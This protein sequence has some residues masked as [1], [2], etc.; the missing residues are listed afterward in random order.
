[1]Q[2][3]L[4]SAFLAAYLDPAEPTPSCAQY[5]IGWEGAEA[6]LRAAHERTIQRANA[7]Q[8]LPQSLGIPRAGARLPE[9]RSEAT[10]ELLFLSREEKE[11]RG[12]AAQNPP[13]FSRGSL[14]EGYGYVLRRVGETAHQ[15]CL[16]VT[17][18]EKPADLVL[19]EGTR[20]LVRV[21][22]L[23]G[24]DADA[25]AQLLAE[26]G[27]VGT[28]EERA[29]L[30][31]AYA[32][33]PLALK[34]VAETIADLF[35]GEIGPFLKQSVVIFGSIQELL[36]EQIA[37][38]SAVEQIVLRWLAIVREPLS[39]EDLLVLL[40][41]PGPAG[42]MLSAVDNLRRRSLIER[43]KLPGSFTLHSVVLGY[44]TRLLIEE[45]THEITQGQ[46]SRLIEHGLSHAGAREDVR[47]TQE[48]LIVAPILAHLRSAYPGRAEVEERLLSLLAQ[49]R[50]RADYAQGY[51]PA[52]L[53]ALLRELRGHLRGLDLSQL[54]LRGAY[55]QGVE[56][57]DTTLAGATLRETVWTSALDAT[58][59]VAISGNGQ[60]W[61]SLGRD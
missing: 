61:A 27:V 60:Y 54:A 8:V 13:C 10:Q 21:L 40:V 23:G 1:V 12:S 58:N 22:R 26:K 38:L 30:V 47:Q 4:Y 20:S 44:V 35:V 14:Q 41:A 6:R 18:R 2:R 15:S 5:V 59:A 56:M 57:Q 9:S 34:V 28:P 39:L 51:G 50:E 49:L 53:V 52:N 7:G 25:G 45:A 55:L 42:Q 19:L 32:G 33:N 46:L 16:L 43:G 36:A 11:K 3:D 31:E 37:R 17:S 24:L 48:R 29:R